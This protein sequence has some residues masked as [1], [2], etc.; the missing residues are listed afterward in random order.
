MNEASFLDSVAAICGTLRV[1][2]LIDREA[3]VSDLLAEHL[4]QA[5]LL[6]GREETIG[7]GRRIDIVVAHPDGDRRQRIGI[8]VKRRRPSPQVAAQLDRYGKA[9]L[10]GLILFCERSVTVAHDEALPVRV[11]GF[12]RGWGIAL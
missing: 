2:D 12:G 6:V 1:P 9:G 4:T 11:V 8:E 5:G 7:K 3:G 10:G